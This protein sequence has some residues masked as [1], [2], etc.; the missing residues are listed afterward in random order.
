MQLQFIN[1]MKQVEYRPKL[2]LQKSLTDKTIEL[3]T[4]IIL[5]LCWTISIYFY[6]QAPHK[7]VSHFNLQGI[8]DGYSSKAFLFFL[9]ILTSFIVILLF[10]LNK[11]PHKFNYLEKVTAENVEDVYKKGMLLVRLLN[12]FVTIFLSFIQTIIAKSTFSQALPK[13]FLLIVLVVPIFTPII[14][15]VFSLKKSKK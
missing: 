1:Q 13:Y 11:Y 15:I 8:P 6:M 4:F 9:P 12:L 14:L 2:D 5:I 7:V 3:A 10:I